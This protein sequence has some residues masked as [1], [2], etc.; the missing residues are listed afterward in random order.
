MLNK[1]ASPHKPTEI[2]EICRTSGKSGAV[3]RTAPHAT[4][5]L[6]LSAAKLA[7]KWRLLLPTYHFGDHRR[8]SAYGCK[9]FP[10]I[11]SMPSGSTIQA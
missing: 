11:G 1:A 2:L 6:F 4:F 3:T 7:R 10:R 5:L 9:R 8:L